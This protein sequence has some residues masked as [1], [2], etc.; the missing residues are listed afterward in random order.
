MSTWVVLGRR[1]SDKLCANHV[2]V[3]GDWKYFCFGVE[4]RDW[5]CLC[6]SCDCS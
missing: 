5:C 2:K 6:A 1:F 3:F 4:M